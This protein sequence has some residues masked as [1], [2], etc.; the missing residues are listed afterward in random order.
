MS[1]INDLVKQISNP[2]LRSKIEDELNKLVKQKKFGLVFE[3]HLPETTVL[4]DIPVKKGATV[5]IK[6][7][8]SS[9]LYRVAKIE[10]DKA[11][12]V[13]NDGKIYEFVTEE[14]V[15]TAKLG[16]PIY[17]Y[18]KKIDECCN[19]PDSP[20]WHTLIEA[21]NYHALQLLVY[22]Y[23]GKVD[24]IYIDPPYNTGAKDWKY[25]N[26][27]VDSNDAYRH[28]KWLSM[29]KR[30]LELAKKLLNP[31]DSVLI[32]TIDEKEYLHLGC[33]LEELFPEARHQMVSVQITPQGNPRD[34]QFYRTN[35]F[36]FFLGFGKAQPQP[37]AL[38]SN[39]RT[40]LGD[41]PVKN[42]NWA[43]F[44]RTGTARKREDRPNMFYPFFI[45][46]TVNGPVIDTIGEPFY[47]SDLSKVKGPEGTVTVWPI[48]KDGELRR[49]QYAA[50]GARK[51]KEE[52]F[53]RL[54]KWKGE[55]T[56]IQ[57]LAESNR[58][59]ILKGEIPISGRSYDGSFIVDENHVAS[60]IPGTLWR[61]PSHDATRAGT[62]LLKKVLG[63]KRFNYP[64]SLYAVYDT[65]KFYVKH[66]PDALILDFFAGS[67]TTQHA[68]ELL[69]AADDGHRRCISITNNELSLEEAK[70]LTEKGLQQGDSEW[71][72]KGIARYITWPRISCSIK[73][74][75]VKN[76]KLEGTYGGDVD[77]YQ[78]YECVVIDPITEKKESKKLYQKIKKT[79]YPELADR[80][81]KD[82]FLANA[83]FF[84]LGFLDKNQ[85][86]LGTQLSELIS[87]LWMKAGAQGQCPNLNAGNIDYKIF[88]KNKFAILVKENT[89]FKFVEELNK[90]KEI[91]TVF[92]VTDSESG[93]REMIRHLPSSVKNTYQLYSD[94]LDN[95]RII[96]GR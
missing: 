58:A 48:G 80:E 75:N 53:L 86:S 70:D 63:E 96:S 60:F 8:S 88:S 52:G 46:N 81:L 9:G 21:E 95:F 1:A 51:L 65:I 35:E 10:G 37:L 36:I 61:I 39:W 69:N 76:E 41:N 94:Y 74:I 44:L 49:W 66:K 2:E 38:D 43:S 18:L 83:I 26:D 5:S 22:L 77:T 93:Y 17:P 57:Y 24:C 64:K 6:A 47:E 23:G 14:L 19:A 45:K 25:N 20:L 16:E 73:G 28:S 55:N 4:Y 84:K 82:G 27:Y 15:T 50:K 30:R 87:L 11:V 34:Q 56:A 3:E 40:G 59:S 79:S 92:L 62:Q 42:I 90:E 31:E 54:G 7:K 68:V 29:M 12:C 78:P 89:F 67:G 13:D 85:V 33:L 32:I 72:E 71:E 91:R